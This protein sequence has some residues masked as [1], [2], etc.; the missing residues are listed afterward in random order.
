MLR[1]MREG[2]AGIKVAT[3]AAR[4]GL[5]FLLGLAMLGLSST[6]VLAVPITTDLTITGST[7]FDDG[8]AFVG[9]AT[10]TQS[11]GYGAIEGGTTTTTTF[12]DTTTTGDDPR[13]GTFTD[14]GDGFEFTGSG[15]GSADDDEFAF[16]LDVSFDLTNNSAT[17]TYKITFL[18][19][20]DH[21]VDSEGV[22]AF[23]ISEF[24]VEQPVNTEIFFTFVA[25]D[26]LN[27][28]EDSNGGLGTFGAEVSEDGTFFFDVTLAPGAM[29]SIFSAY[30]A[31]GGVFDGTLASLDFAGSITIDAVMNLTPP[32]QPVPEPGT[33]LVFGTGL[34]GL[35]F[36][37][38]RRRKRRD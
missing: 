10:G 8:F 5:G 9:G 16:G 13:L 32:P 38:R 2:I 23:A 25:S 24:F 3:D 21:T 30:T 20:F 11:G 27:G 6:A 37:A 22:D 35:G 17:D 1:E 14:T 33:L 36:V 7:D 4:V 18:V 15:G 29:A 34:L 12:G 19:T 26:T 28:D 31:E